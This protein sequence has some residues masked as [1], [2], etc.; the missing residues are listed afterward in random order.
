MAG[1]HR[2]SASK[3]ADKDLKNSDVCVEVENIVD[4]MNKDTLWKVDSIPRLD[5]LPDHEAS[6]IVKGEAVEEAYQSIWFGQS[7]DLKDSDYRSNEG[8]L[9]SILANFQNVFRL[10]LQ[11]Y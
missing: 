3:P 8:F 9:F 5:C 10:T 6:E 4:E 2:P 11:N 7:K 1:K